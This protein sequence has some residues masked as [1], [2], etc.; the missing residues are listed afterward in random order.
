M[1]ALRR[2]QLNCDVHSSKIEIWIL[3]YF[4]LHT[5]ENAGKQLKKGVLEDNFS[6]YYIQ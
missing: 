2:P 1:L 4:I 3:Y 6:W 5:M